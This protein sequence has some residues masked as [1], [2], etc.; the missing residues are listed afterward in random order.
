M[1]SRKE[2]GQKPHAPMNSETYW[3]RRFETDW[4]VNRGREQSV[5][6]GRIILDHLPE[7]LTRSLRDERWTICDWG[8]LWATVR[9]SWLKC[10][11]ARSQGS[12]SPNPRLPRRARHLASRIFCGSTFFANC[13][14][15]V[16]MWLSPPTPLSTSTIPWPSSSVSGKWQPKLL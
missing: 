15:S 1:S 2:A 11:Q 8:A 5:F 6:F 10:S 7:W 9:T 3:S 16:S 14:M 13:S 12:I 4:V